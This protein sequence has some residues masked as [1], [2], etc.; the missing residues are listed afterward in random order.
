ML[1]SVI[2][3]HLDLLETSILEEKEML[4][5]Q[6]IDSIEELLVNNPDIQSQLE[7]RVLIEKCYYAASI[8]TKDKFK[9]LRY[10]DIAIMR[11]ACP[12]LS[13]RIHKHALNLQKDLL[14]DK[15]YPPLNITSSHSSLKYDS[16]TTL[17]SEY[18]FIDHF[19]SNPQKAC[20]IKG[21]TLSP[22]HLKWM[23]MNYL[24][25]K[26]GAYRCVPIEKGRDY[27]AQDFTVKLE[28]FHV[29]ISYCVSMD[30]SSENHEKAENH[31]Q[32]IDNVNAMNTIDND[33]KNKMWYMAQHDLM[34]QVKG[35]SD[36]IWIPDI[37]F[38]KESYSGVRIRVWIGPK[39]TFSPLHTDP[40][41][42]IFVGVV[43][44]KVFKLIVRK[45][46]EEKE[47]IVGPGDMLFIPVCR[48]Y[49]SLSN[50]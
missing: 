42:N 49:A 47:I 13:T 24:V 36:D 46:E 41:D 33:L 38:V 12:L 22:A 9:S 45:G 18:A 4:V 23:D 15:Q 43:G 34:M 28:F 6:M 5:L 50:P 37:C 19:H 31:N 48:S 39:G 26:V 30:E 21:M 7:T 32:T 25:K 44:F 1:F 11:T 17:Y 14:F 29:F 27:L 10:L 3:H 20:I 16:I 2:H 8:H 40:E 35:L